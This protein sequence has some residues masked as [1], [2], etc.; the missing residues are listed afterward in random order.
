[1][2][3]VTRRTVL[4]TLALSPAVTGRA[5]PAAIRTPPGSLPDTTLLP[6]WPG[7]PPGGGGPEN[8]AP[9]VSANGSL[10][11]IAAPTLQIYR[12]ARP[13]GAA[14]IMAAGGGYQHITQ[15]KEATPATRWLQKLGITVGVLTYRLPMEGWH[16]ASLAPFQDAQRA[17]RLLRTHARQYGIDPDRIG[18]L[19]FSAG[20]HLLGLCATRPDWQT[21]SPTDTADTAPIKV[22]LALLAYPIISLEPPY[23][24]THTSRTLL[25]PHPTQADARAWSIPPYIRHGSPPFFLVQAADD[26]IAAPGQT[27]LLEQACQQNAVPVTRH[28]FASGGHGFGLGRPGTP[29]LTWP[30]LAEQFLHE[31]SFIS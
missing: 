21:Y 10:T 7:T 2:F 1:M 31:Q 19:G 14:M 12:P 6:L 9:L 22:A 30:H 28:L 8:L 15:R 17:I 16:A 11:R 25:G 13:N 27:A 24:H 5:E 29:T 20:G 23:N 18:I 4:T 26:P 3:R